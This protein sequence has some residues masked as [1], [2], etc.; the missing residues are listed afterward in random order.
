MDDKIKSVMAEVFEIPIDEI[1]INSSSQNIQ[2]WDSLKHMNMIIALEEEFGIFFN[3]D[4][5]PEI[6]SFRKI[7]D[8]L[9]RLT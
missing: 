5:I 4:D 8:A 9:K 6:Q 7:S 3:E 2:N 1:S